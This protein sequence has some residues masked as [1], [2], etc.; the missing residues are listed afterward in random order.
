MTRSMRR[1]MRR[2][3]FS[4]SARCAW[5]LPPPPVLALTIAA[6]LLSLSAT[7]NTSAQEEEL[8]LDGTAVRY[9][10]PE[11]GGAAKPRFIA[12]RVLAFQSVVEAKIEDQAS[13]GVQDRHVRTA[14]DRLVVEGVLSSLPLDHPPDARELAGLVALLRAGVAERLGGDD[15][16]QAA[17]QAHGLASEEVDALFT[18]RAR[19]ALYADRSLSPVL[20]PSEEQLREVFRTAAHPFRGRRFE[21]VR[22]R[23]GAWFVEE[24]LRA[25][26]GAFMQ[27]A[28]ARIRVVAV[29][30]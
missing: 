15:A 5:P 1:W 4:S 8:A 16:L 21:D 19:A 2:L 22:T 7:R 30:R 24:R 3:T 13:V 20:S 6:A 9:Y 27:S 29:R 14:M 18:R 10:A 28:R 23:L 26:L 12:Q 17:A 11:I 25:T